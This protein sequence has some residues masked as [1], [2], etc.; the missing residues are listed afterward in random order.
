[1]CSNK[2]YYF[3]CNT[4]LYGRICPLFLSRLFKS[5]MNFHTSWKKLNLFSVS[6]VFI[7]YEYKKQ[8]T[9]GRT[10]HLLSCQTIRAQLK[11]TPPTIFRWGRN[12]CTKLLPSND[13]EIHFTVPLHSTDRRATH[14]DTQTYGRYLWNT[15]MKWGSGAVV[16]IPSIMKI[17]SGIRKLMGWKF[18]Q[19]HR[20]SFEIA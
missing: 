20:D 9:A 3:F 2:L 15:P 7:S 1:M 10:N 5:W 17:G 12:V 13:N 4:Q 11:T 16:Y 6:V 19:R 14:T 18:I 8:E